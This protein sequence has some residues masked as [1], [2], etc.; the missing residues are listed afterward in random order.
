MIMADTNIRNKEIH[1]IPFQTLDGILS[2]EPIAV[3]S[4]AYTHIPFDTS[5]QRLREAGYDG[6]FNV[7]YE[8]SFGERGRGSRGVRFEKIGEK[9]IF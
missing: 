7:R 9:I 6:L 1:S 5:L 4:P 2:W 3:R 8:C